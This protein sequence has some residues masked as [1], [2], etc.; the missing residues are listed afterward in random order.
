MAKRGAYTRRGERK[1]NRTERRQM[2]Q[3]NRLLWGRSVARSCERFFS[4]RHM[5]PGPISDNFIGS[6]DAGNELGH[7]FERY[8]GGD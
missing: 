3:T 1:F 6:P 2:D 8:D 5:D 4:E 7:G